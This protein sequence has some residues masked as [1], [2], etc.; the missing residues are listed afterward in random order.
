VDSCLVLVLA[1]ASIEPRSVKYQRSAIVI[2][3]MSDIDRLKTETSEKQL[4]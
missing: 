2:V 1:L 4:Y 3:L